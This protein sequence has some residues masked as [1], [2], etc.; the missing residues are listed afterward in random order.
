MRSTLS[1]VT[2]WTL[3]Q[4]RKDSAFHPTQLILQARSLLQIFKMPIAQT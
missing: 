2:D 4:L 3:I 1:A